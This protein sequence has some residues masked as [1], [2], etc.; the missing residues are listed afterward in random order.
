[1]NY[2]TAEYEQDFAAWIQHHIA[3]LKQGKFNEIDVEHL[4]EE[5]EDMGKSHRREL[6]N[7][8]I[9]LIAHLLKWQYQYQ[10]LQDQWKTFI[11]GSWRGTIMEQRTKIA[12]LLKQSPSLKR[13][14]QAA[15][16][17]A[18]PDAL[19]IALSETG[20]SRCVFPDTCPYTLEQLQDENFYP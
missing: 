6:V 1:M 12:K 13:E 5:L 4:I 11:G 16:N 18:Y 8:F 10:Q 19:K 7:R 3:L 17:E 15:I 2:L 20:L 14:L 9:P